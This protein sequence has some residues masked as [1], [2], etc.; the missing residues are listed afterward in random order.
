MPIEIELQDSRQDMFIVKEVKN[1]T[2]TSP[3]IILTLKE[4]LVGYEHYY[5]FSLKL[6]IFDSPEIKTISNYLFHFSSFDFYISKTHVHITEQL[7]AQNLH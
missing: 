3:H 2:L 7:R 6:W 5:I 4:R 1:E